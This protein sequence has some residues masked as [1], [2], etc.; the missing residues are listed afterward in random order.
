MAMALPEGCDQEKL[1]ETAI[2]LLYLTTH[3][4]GPVPRAWK[5][6]DWDLLDLLFEKGWIGDPKSKARS[7]VLTQEGQSVSEEMFSK[8]FGARSSSCDATI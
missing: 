5:G 3:L 1:A 7:V 2:A 6:L 4:D 8:H